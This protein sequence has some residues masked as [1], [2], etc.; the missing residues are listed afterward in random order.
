MKHV[1]AL[2]MMVAMFCGLA[3]STPSQAR[4]VEVRATHQQVQKHHA[5]KATRHRAPK[6]TRHSV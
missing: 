6:R 3:W 5:H 1:I 2:G 4:L